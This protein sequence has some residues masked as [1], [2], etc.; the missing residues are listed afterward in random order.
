MILLCYY[1]SKSLIYNDSIENSLISHKQ[2]S[3]LIIGM[4][5]VGAITPA[6]S[7]N[8]AYGL[9]LT[10]VSANPANTISFKGTQYAIVVQPGQT[11]TV[12]TIVTTF[13][14]GT[15]I[16]ADAKVSIVTLNNQ[17]L[18]GTAVFDNT[19]H[20]VTFTLDTAT[21]MTT[22]DKIFLLIQ[23]IRNPT[24]PGTGPLT[25]TL[26]VTTLDSLSAIIDGPT[27]L[28]YNIQ[29]E[30]SGATGATG[31]T[32]NNGAT[33]ATGT[34]GT[35]GATGP[36]GN[37]GDTGATGPTGTN[38]SDGAAGTGVDV[39]TLNS[40]G[41]INDNFFIGL[42]TN[43]VS[44]FANQVKIPVAGIIDNLTVEVATDMSSGDTNTYTIRINGVAASPSLSCS[45]VG[46]AGTD[47][48]CTA[49][50]TGT[51]SVSAGDRV[52]IQLTET[53]GN[54]AQKQTMASFT[55]RST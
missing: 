38:G 34:D 37:T 42:G 23:K 5:V 6:L 52:S 2:T 19:A 44:E 31:A 40:F 53:V 46:T 32:G 18:T 24:N 28:G 51:L 3:M 41:T 39:I 12:K 1:L 43:S 7:F 35:N 26:S 11:G 30:T 29:P 54:S 20:T 8:Q 9:P 21:S 27:T 15:T 22:T 45:I 55:F 36:T 50:T 47:V 25:Q 10:N 16:P 14:S 4:L 13:P 48:A 17:V 33:G 49:T